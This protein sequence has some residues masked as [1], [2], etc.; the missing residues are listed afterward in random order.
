MTLEDGTNDPW[1]DAAVVADY[2]T[3]GPVDAGEAA[4]IAHITPR[5]ANSRFLD[6]GVGGGRT[7]GMV[8]H[9]VKSYRGI[10]ISPGM[11]ELARSRFPAL[12][13]SVGDAS[14][15]TDVEDASVDVLLFSLNGLDCLP[16]ADRTRA[17][18]EFARVVAPGGELVLSTFSIDGPSYGETPDRRN[19]RPGIVNGI[20]TSI[21]RRRVPRGTRE[22]ERRAYASAAVTASSGDGWATAPVAAHGWRFVVRFAHFDVDVRELDEVGFDVEAAFLPNGVPIPLDAHEVTGDYFY[23]VAVRR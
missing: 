20:R 18:R 14:A 8:A 6:V 19:R 23:L 7:S 1:G 21:R 2:A 5:L 9:R 13:L 3:D 12:D 11:L 4:A 16:P 22:A 15:L 10:D 17:L